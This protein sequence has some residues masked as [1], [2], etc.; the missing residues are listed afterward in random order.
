MECISVIEDLQTKSRATLISRIYS[1]KGQE[2]I[3]PEDRA[4]PQQKG[5]QGTLVKEQKDLHTDGRAKP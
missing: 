4:S 2:D 1:S 5:H 3:H